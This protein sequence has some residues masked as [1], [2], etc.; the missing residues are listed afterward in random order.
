MV[1]AIDVLGYEGADHASVLQ[2]GERVVCWVWKGATDG[3]EPDVCT[4][5]GE[6]HEMDSPH[7]AC[8]QD[9]HQYR[10]L[11]IYSTCKITGSWDRLKE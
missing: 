3:Q 4:K 11:T 7:R 8:A 10:C 5:P 9:T 2:C 1:Q 6:H